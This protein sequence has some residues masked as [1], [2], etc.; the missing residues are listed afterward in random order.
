MK[1]SLTFFGCP[2]N[3]VDTEACL[4]AFLKN[5]CSIVRRVEE[6]D[7]AFLSTCAFIKPARREVE[8][9]IKEYLALKRK[10]VIKKLVVFGC[11]VQEERERLLKLFPEVDSFIGLDYI[12]RIPRLIKEGKKIIYKKHPTYLSFPRYLQ[13][14]SYAYLKI[15][16]GCSNFCAYCR[17]PYIRGSY[18]SRPK[19]EI[20]KEAKEIAQMGRREL[21][22]VSQ[23]STLYGTDLYSFPSLHSLLK[24]LVKIKEVSWIRILYTHPA[25][26]Y[27]EL[28]SFI[29]NE[30]KVL[31]YIDLPLQHISDRILS[32]MNRG[33]KRRDVEKILVSLKKIPGMVLRTTFIVGFPQEKEEDFA[34]L[35]NFLEEWRFDHI[36][37]F[38]YSPER[39]TPA[40]SLSPK[41][42]YP[43]KL[44]RRRVLMTLA[45]KIAQEKLTQLVGKEMAVIIDQKREGKKFNY[46]G[47]TYRDAPEIDG[48][49]F[50]RGDGLK[51]GEIYPLRIRRA[52]A[53]HLYAKWR[54]GDLNPGRK[55]EN[56][57]S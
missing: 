17:I 22:L 56:L 3:F 41:I 43:E 26:I 25:H 27:P 30:E 40:D 42:P 12:P 33:Y 50:I 14:L 38:L 16:E 1:V 7:V 20:I 9:K 31:K 32:L 54:H 11:L 34:S 44:E 48:K 5:N 46:L 39:E 10:R 53:Y 51:V 13:T 28:L 4:A 36:G 49:V 29:E 55:V 2:K 24:E 8:K 18:R 23:D 35:L 45:K 6:S 21:I 15:S 47:R 19:E 37:C 52:D 57:V